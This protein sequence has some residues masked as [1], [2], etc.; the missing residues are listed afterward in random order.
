[1]IPCSLVDRYQC[2]I[3]KFGLCLHCRN[4]QSE[5]WMTCLW[6]DN[7][8]TLISLEFRASLIINRSTVAKSL[9]CSSF[10]R[11]SMTTNFL[12]ASLYLLCFNYHSTALSCLSQFPCMRALSRPWLGA[13]RTPHMDLTSVCSSV[14]ASMG[15]CTSG[16][17]LLRIQCGRF[18]HQIRHTDSWQ[19]LACPAYQNI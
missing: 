14:S 1:M 12:L 11:V 13:K 19:S 7:V 6:C 5:N 16:A 9:N 2:F 15:A 4:E 18:S 8:D 3:E 17:D 10:S